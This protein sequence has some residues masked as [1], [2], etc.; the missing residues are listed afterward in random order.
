MRRNI[1]YTPNQCKMLTEL[2]GR[3]GWQPN[4]VS[5]ALPVS[6]CYYSYMQIDRHRAQIKRQRKAED[7]KKKETSAQAVDQSGK[8]HHKYKTLKFSL[9][10]RAQ[11]LCFLKKK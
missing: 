11:V 2:S 7:G 3:K 9:Y 10:S 1:D 4:C 8:H 5:G 6:R